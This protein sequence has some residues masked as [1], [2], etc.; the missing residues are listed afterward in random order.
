MTEAAATP[1]QNRD[2]PIK[3]SELDPKFKY[4][5]QKTHGSEKILKCFQCGTCS[6][7]DLCFLLCPDVSIA[8]DGKNGYLVKTDYCK[9]CSICA[10][11]CPRHVIEMEDSR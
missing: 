7:C 3:A 9:G 1:A 8:K 4:E 10:T 5:L 11:T 6:Q 2:Q